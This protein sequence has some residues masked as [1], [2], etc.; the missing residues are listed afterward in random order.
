MPK[1]VGD[2]CRLYIPQSSS[3]MFGILPHE[4]RKFLFQ[5]RDPP[6]ESPELNLEEDDAEVLGTGTC[7]VAE[8]AAGF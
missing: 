8:F 4:T 5:C 7:R 6:Q 3:E 2:R 1:N